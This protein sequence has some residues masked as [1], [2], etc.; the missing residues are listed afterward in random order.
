MRLLRQVGIPLLAIL[1]LLSLLLAAVILIYEQKGRML[2][3]AS[4]SGNETTE[5]SNHQP[6]VVE[7]IQENY[8]PD[9]RILK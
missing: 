9:W 8:N 5:A 7:Y 2:P 1:I 3:F 4:H 6:S